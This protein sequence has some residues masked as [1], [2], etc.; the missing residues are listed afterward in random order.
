MNPKD[1]N[2]PTW[3]IKTLVSNHNCLRDMKN[4]NITSRWIAKHYLHKFIT[5][6]KYSITSLQQDVKIDFLIT[7]SLT[8]CT[9]ARQMALKIVNG[10]QKEQ[11]SKICEYLNEIRVTNKGSITICFL[12][13]RLFQ[14]MYV[15]LDTLKKGFKACNPLIS[16]DGCFLKGYYG[17]QLF[18]VVGIDAND[19]IYPIAYAAV[20]SENSES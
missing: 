11:Y 8:K 2:D 14:R 18:V 5:D 19:C 9:K 12:E 3:Q 10:N 6:P 7:V 4:R 20:E 13:A 15:C 17:G 16:L 1:D